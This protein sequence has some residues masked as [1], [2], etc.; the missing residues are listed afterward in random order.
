MELEPDDTPVE[1]AQ[2]ERDRA[3]DVA[4]VL[5]Q[6]RWPVDIGGTGGAV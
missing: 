3:R 6:D 2:V 5:E 1:V 4:V